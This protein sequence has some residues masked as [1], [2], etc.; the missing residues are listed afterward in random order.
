V[1]TLKNSR[2]SNL[3]LKYHCLDI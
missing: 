1:S 2:L 3:Q